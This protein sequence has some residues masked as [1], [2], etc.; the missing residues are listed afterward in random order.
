[1]E[2]ASKPNVGEKAPASAPEARPDPGPDLIEGLK[3]LFS[4]ER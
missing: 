2:S 3:R 4:G 1:M